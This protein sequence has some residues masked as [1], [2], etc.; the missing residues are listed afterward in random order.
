MPMPVLIRPGRDDDADAFIALIWAYWSRYPGI[1]MDVEQEM[2]ELRRLATYYRDHGGALWAAESDGHLVGMVATR[3]LDAG[4]WE[5]CRVYV[6]PAHHGAGLG[7]DLLTRAETHAIAAGATR[8]VLWTDTRFD[9]AHRFY[10]KRSYVR[11]G[12]IR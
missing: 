10:E 3:P 8:L 6:D 1:R 2:P 7:H 9:R 4:A 5:I 12:P 11:S